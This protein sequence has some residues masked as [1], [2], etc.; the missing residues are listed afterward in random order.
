ML[1]S[2]S[3]VI[4]PLL[5][6]LPVRIYNRM[7]QDASFSVI[8]RPFYSRIRS[9]GT[10]INMLAYLMSGRW[11]PASTCRPTHSTPPNH[12]WF[13]TKSACVE[14]KIPCS[15]HAQPSSSCPC[16]PLDQTTPLLHARPHA[17]HYWVELLCWMPAGIDSLHA[18]GPACTPCMSCTT[19]THVSSR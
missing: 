3:S 5:A 8:H 9:S 13:G 2:I 1:P 16:D 6:V 17:T 15:L 18:P 10:C 19:L 4:G 7:P 14:R 12:S 11:H